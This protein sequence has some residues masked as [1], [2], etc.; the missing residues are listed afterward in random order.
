M[1]K[2]IK[3][4]LK[5]K[6][7]IKEEKHLKN[8]IKKIETKKKAY[9]S[10]CLFLAFLFAFS[11]PIFLKTYAKEKLSLDEQKT[12]VEQNIQEAE[13]KRQQIEVNL[14]ENSKELLEIEEKLVVQ[15]LE[16]TKLE[17]KEYTLNLEGQ[18]I[19]KELK[20]LEENVEKIKE[21]T[22]ERLIAIYEEGEYSKWEVLLNANNLADF[23]EKYRM[24]EEV[25]K[26]DAKLFEQANLQFETQKK[27]EETFK[28]IYDNLMQMKKTLAQKKVIQ[29]NLMILKND[30]ISNLSNEQRETFENIQKLENARR[31]IEEEIKS[32]QTIFGRID[33][34]VGG[35]LAWPVPLCNSTKWITA[36]YGAGYSQGYPGFFHTG[37][38]IA[39]P[40]AIVGQATAVAAADGRVITAGRSN[41]GYGNYV[42]IDHGGGVF[43]LY[44]HASKLLVSA[45]DMVKQGQD[46]IIIGSTGNSTGPHL[47]FEVRIG[48]SDFKYHTD[49]LPYITTPKV[50]LEDIKDIIEEKSDKD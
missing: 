31:K 34:Y 12:L 15:N 1:K 40:Y 24:L 39:P 47:H 32:S 23:F 16:I 2:T 37:V 29:E 48:G 38:D 30:K 8:K 20:I 22:I 14:D 7:R 35:T 28:N 44:G 19:E 45:G 6:N 3:E 10:I 50:P 26:N 9:I 21:A 36:R 41:Y 5:V 13:K 11:K 49:P 43:T 17:E 25:A 18:Q 46:V 27:K 4:N 42:V 33:R